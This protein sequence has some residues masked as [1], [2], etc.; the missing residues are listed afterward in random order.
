MQLKYDVIIVG[1]GL[2]GIWTA[3]NLDKKLKVLVLTK[4]KVWGCNSF[5]AQG[6]V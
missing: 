5:Y 4:S 6:G 2:A 3:L 1:S